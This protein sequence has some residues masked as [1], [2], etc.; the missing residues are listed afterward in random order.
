[1]QQAP[2]LWV[3]YTADQAEDARY[4]GAALRAAGSG[5]KV[6]GLPALRYENRRAGQPIVRLA[7]DTAT[8]ME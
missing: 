7:T 6:P 2:R 1:M 3:H 4:L 8:T 5:S